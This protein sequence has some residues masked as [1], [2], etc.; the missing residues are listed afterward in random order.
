MV[1]TKNSIIP[2]FTVALVVFLIVVSPILPFSKGLLSVFVLTLLI[3]TARKIMFD[4]GKTKAAF[5]TALIFSI[6]FSGVAVLQDIHSFDLT[7]VVEFLLVFFVTCLGVFCYGLPVSIIAELVSS[8]FPA[9]RKGVSAMIYVG[10]GLCTAIFGLFDGLDFRVFI[11]STICAVLF[12]FMD[13]WNRRKKS[14]LP[15]LPQPS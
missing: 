10:F 4:H 2:A 8:R 12:F 14:T 7:Y 11:F 13:E 6:G 3:P 1:L 5:Y 9:S 15:R